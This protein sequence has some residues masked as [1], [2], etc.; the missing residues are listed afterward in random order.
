MTGALLD[1]VQV[2]IFVKIFLSTFDKKFSKGSA[3]LWLGLNKWEELCKV[4]K[5]GYG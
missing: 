4:N 5:V 1:L 2:N 3:H